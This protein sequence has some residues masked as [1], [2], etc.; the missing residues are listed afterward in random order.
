MK[1]LLLLGTA[2]LL[3]EVALAQLQNTD[4]ETWVMPINGEINANR[5]VSWLRTNGISLNQNQFYHPPVTEAQNGNYAL[6]MSI[7][8]TY[9]ED[10]AIQTAPINYRPAALTGFYTY[11][12]NL[13]FSHFTNNIVDDEAR[14]SV[15]L[16][17]AN[18]ATGEVEVVGTGTIILPPSGVYTQFTCPILYTSGAIPDAI[19]V[20]FDSSL[21]DRF[22]DGAYT[23]PALTG[24][25]SILTVDNIALTTTLADADLTKTKLSIYPNPVSDILYLSEF[26]GIATIFDMT[27]KRITA[28]EGTIKKIDVST[29]Q[30][31]IYIVSINDN[32]GVQTLKLIKK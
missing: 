4:F 11:T 7:W 26:E 30:T 1:K 16:T 21:M 27:G 9:D 14:V 8:Y 6:R 28:H 20:V 24:V 12:D 2:L 3:H 18:N 19:E 10:M 17:K 29:L 31:G 13:V 32:T 5:P 23:S 22:T 25:S 15:K